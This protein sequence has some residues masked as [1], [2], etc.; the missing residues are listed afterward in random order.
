ML[1]DYNWVYI[2]LKNLVS[3]KE[4]LIKRGKL[5][6]LEKREL[7]DTIKSLKEGGFSNVVEA[8]GF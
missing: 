3:Y 8:L 1:N 5:T 4:I 7:E 2:D 6:C